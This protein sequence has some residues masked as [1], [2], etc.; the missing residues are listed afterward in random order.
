MS[1]L[2]SSPTGIF[3][4]KPV[5]EVEPEDLEEGGGLQRVLGLWQLTAIGIGGIIGAG[6]FSLAGAVANEKAGPGVL[7]SFL[8]AGVASACAALSY[9][10]FAGIV[11]KAGSAYTYGYV[12]LGEGV[13]WFIGW[14][15]LLEYTAIVAVVGI[16]ISGYF[17]F[18]VEQIGLN[19]P[20]WMLGAPGSDPDQP[21]R[22]VDLF[23]LLLCL[24]IAFILT[25]GVRSAARVET[26]LVWLKVGVVVL[27]V[28]LGVF[29]VNTDNYTPFL[30]FGWGGVFAG[31]SVV[32]FAVFGYDAMSTAAE[33]S[34]QARKLLPKA[35]ILSLVISMILYVLACLVLTG[36]VKYTDV[37]PESAFA[38]AFEGVGLPWIATLISVGAILGIATVMWTFM[39]AVTRVWFSMS[40]DGLLPK[41]FAAVNRQAVGLSGSSAMSTS[42]YA[43]V[44]C[45]G[46]TMSSAASSRAC[47]SQPWFQPSLVAAAMNTSSGALPA[48]APMPVNDASTRLAPCSTAT[49]ELAT[50]SDRL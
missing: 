15:L 19:L 2:S 12:V 24:L 49:I 47:R 39:Y 25:R 22:V 48:P 20:E 7:L 44:S 40:R 34:T 38:Q 50:P 37:D 3:R 33:E 30:P 9:A 35:I 42:S 4:R 10:E 26:L 41:W 28:V 13:G 29:Y 32:F 23:A 18:L 27:I 36:M 6:I 8:V 1:I 45:N 11:P 5:D 14:D 31:A 16:G 46:R 43:G 21:G 17:G